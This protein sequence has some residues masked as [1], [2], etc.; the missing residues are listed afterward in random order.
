MP[1]GL[2]DNHH[3]VGARL[4]GP[5]DFPQMQLHCLG[6]APGHDQPGALARL[7]ADGAEDVG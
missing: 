1:S 6:I 3:G 4:D 7:G 2:I 5:G